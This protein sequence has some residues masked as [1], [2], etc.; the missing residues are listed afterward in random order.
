LATWGLIK[1]IKSTLNKL[2]TEKF[3]NNQFWAYSW[4]LFLGKCSQLDISRKVTLNSFQGLLSR[5]MLK[6][7]LPA[8]RK[9]SMT[10][11]HESV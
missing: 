7:S 6:P 5:E 9:F 11:R 3:Q 8:G 10:L 1:Q 2:K 4:I